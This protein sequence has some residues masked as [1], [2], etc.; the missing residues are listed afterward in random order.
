MTHK[1]RAPAL[2]CDTFIPKIIRRGVKHS[3]CNFGMLT[4]N[5]PTF[6]SA[7][8]PSSLPSTAA[9]VIVTRFLPGPLQA[10]REDDR[11]IG[12][13]TYTH[14]PKPRP[15]TC[16]KVPAAFCHSVELDPTSE[17]SHSGPRP[18]ILLREGE[19]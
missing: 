2:D 16:M 8:K 18:S 4:Q 6:Q 3:L 13:I 12:G 9:E 11:G 19:I 5:T 10:D 15:S 14:R 1:L 7:R 17:L